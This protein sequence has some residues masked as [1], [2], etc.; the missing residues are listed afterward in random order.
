VAV[1]AIACSFLAAT[2][3]GGGGLLGSDEIVRGSG[4]LESETHG[5]EGFDSLL[6]E[7]Q[8]EVVVVVD[9]TET[10]TVTADDNVLPHLTIGVNGDRLELG[11]DDD[12]ELSSATVRYA[13]T[14]DAL[15][16]VEVRGSG[17]VLA[18]AIDVDEFGIQISGSGDVE[19]IGVALENPGVHG[20]A[21]SS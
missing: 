4:E 10:L 9:G 8:G 19:P 17:D 6:V 5:V 11:V 12:I 3:C 18:T 1:A 16:S 15:E 21:P 2:S 14:A 13:I 7:G 20:I